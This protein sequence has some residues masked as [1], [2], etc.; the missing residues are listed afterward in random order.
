MVTVG[1][2]LKHH[3]ALDVHCIDRMYLCGYVPRLQTGGGVVTFLKKHRGH[4]IPSP[5][6]LGLM[7]TDF[8]KAVKDYA[9]AN[10]VPVIPFKRKQRKDDVAKA[11]RSQSSVRDGVVFIGV[12]Q[13]KMSSFQATRNGT[14]TARHFTYARHTVMVNQYYFYLHDASFGE[15]FIKVG[16]YFPFPLRVYLNGHEWV[17]R[18]MDREHIKFESLDNGFLSCDEPGRLQEI[19]DELEPRHIKNFLD[20]WLRRLPMPLTEKDRKLGYDYKLSI[21]NLEVSHTQVFTQP[22]RGREFFEAIIRENLDLGRP[23]QVAIIFDRKVTKATPGHFGTRV[24][25]RGVHP[26]IHTYY[27]TTDIKQYFKEHRALRTETT[28]KR[29]RDFKIGSLIDNLPAL[30]KLGRHINDRLLELERVC[31]DCVLSDATMGNLTQPTVAKDGT[32]ASG[33]RFGDP[34]VMALLAALASF[35]HVAGGITNASLRVLVADLM[36]LGAQYT[37]TM[38]SYDLRRLVRKGIIC[39]RP[40]SNA[41]FL[42]PYGAQV[43]VFCTRV[44]ARLFKP[45]LAAMEEDTTVQPISPLREAFEELRRETNV[46]IDNVFKKAV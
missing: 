8:N 44:N 36:G 23:D 7:T 6:L 24:I 1:E 43:A 11:M 40:H 33:L 31:E 9:H 38:M 45:A 13:E 30:R 14:P 34:R 42:T 32:R 37:A 17:K 2:I 29:T 16:S 5:A 12:A 19:C 25:T 39:R 46:L 41:Y 15:G 28:F 22:V 3:V 18:Q 20:K 10:S 35:M 4:P 21:R 27:K 26:S